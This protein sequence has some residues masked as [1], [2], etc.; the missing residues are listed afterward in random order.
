[1]SWIKENPFLASVA[2]VTVVATAG[3][4]YFIS[5]QSSRYNAAYENFSVSSSSISKYNKMKLFPSSSNQTKKKKAIE[6]YEAGIQEV[7]ST[8]KTFMPETLT[9]VPSDQFTGLLSQSS[10]DV[11][12]KLES[13]GVEVPERFLLGFKNYAS[14]TPD[15]SATGE[16]TAQLKSMKWLVEQLGEAK[17]TKLVNLRREK[18]DAEKSKSKEKQTSRRSRRGKPVQEEESFVT[19]QEVQLTFTGSEESLRAFLTSISESKEHMFGIR[20]IRMQ[21]EKLTAPT[22][23]DANF[24]EE[25]ESEDDFG[26]DDGGFVIEEEGEEAVDEVEPAAESGKR[27]LAQVIGSEEVH[28]FLQLELMSF[29][30]A[31]EIAAAE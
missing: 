22:Q 6:A 2:A 4:G 31:S 23:K 10:N 26:D 11:R 21:N 25:I 16:L 14:D 13:A 3:L 29:S 17:I 24:P 7:E 28:V 15:Q 1:M 19:P 27:I 18:I 5:S 12:E 20:R 9:D 8:V 30:P